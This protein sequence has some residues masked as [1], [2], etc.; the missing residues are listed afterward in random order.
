MKYLI[1]LL[2]IIILGFVNP[3]STNAKTWVLSIGIAD[4]VD[5]N[6]D[7]DYAHND[8]IAF[9]ES[10]CENEDVPEDY[11]FLLTNHTATAKAIEENILYI[12]KHRQNDEDV[13]IYFSGHIAGHLQEIEQSDKGTNASQYYILPYDVNRYNELENHIT[14]SEIN[15]WLEP[16]PHSNLII[17]LDACYSGGFE[18]ERG[19]LLASSRR[20]ERSKESS[21]YQHGVFTYFL[22]R[23]LEGKADLNKNNIIDFDELYKYTDLML[24]QNGHNQHPI[25]KDLD[26]I[27]FEKELDTDWLPNTNEDLFKGSIAIAYDNTVFGP[28]VSKPKVKYIFK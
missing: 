17:I 27:L 5:D 25:F 24:C 6:L 11:C 21:E 2:M 12:A 4:Y 7:L 26:D 20:W 8:A 23:G 10:I 3:L 9:L 15:S 14:S 16:I 19:R 18:L 28:G 22:L 1:Y 13:I